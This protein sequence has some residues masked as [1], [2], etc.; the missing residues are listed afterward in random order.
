[1]EEKK[2]KQRAQQSSSNT[3]PRFSGPQNFHNRPTQNP[4]QQQPQFQRYSNN[5]NYQYQRPNCQPQQNNAQMQRSNNQ[6]PR[7]PTPTNTPVKTGTP[8]PP[9]SANCFKCGGTGHWS[10]QC[11]HRGTPQQTPQQN[12]K[13]S[14]PN[15]ASNHAKINHITAEAAQEGPNAVVG[16]FLV[17]SH[18]ALVPFDTGATHSFAT[19]QHVEKYNLPVIKMVC[20]LNVT[21]DIEFSIELVPGTAPI[22]KKAYRIAGVELLEVKKQIDEL[23]EKGFIRKS[24]SPWA[25]LVLLTEKKDGTLRMCV[26]YRGL[27]A[28]TVKN[29]YPLPQIEDLFDQLKS[30]CVFFK[31][32]LRMYDFWIAEVKFQGH[33]I[34][35]GGIA[36]AQSKEGNVIA[37]AFK[38]PRDHEKNYPTHDL[39][40]AA[41]V[42]A[43]KTELN[44]RQRRW[45]ELIKDYDLEIHYHPGKANVVADALSRKSTVSMEF[46]P[47]LEQEIRKGQLNDE[48]IKEIRE[49]IKLDKAPGFRVDAD[50][51]KF[52]WYGMKREVAEYVALCDVCQRVKAKHQKP[53]GLLQPLK[54][55]EWK[56]EEIGMNFIVG[57][58]RTQ[59]GFDSIWVVVD[60][61]TKVA[62]FI[63]V[64][65]IYSGAKLAE[66]Y[67]SRIVCLHG[68][69]KKIVSDRETQFT[70]HFWKRLHESMDTRL[71]F[72]SAYHPQTDGQTKRTNQILEDMLRACAIQYGTSWDKSLPYAEFSYNN[73]Y[74]A[75]IKMSPFQALYGRRCRTPLH[76]DQP[77][78]KQLF[79]PE[80][81]EDAE[82]QV[83]MIRENLRIAQT[84]QKSY[85][86]YR[87]RD[88]EFVVG[89]FLYLKVSPIRGLHRFKVKGKLV[90]RYIGP[91]K[92]ID[93]KGEVAY[94]LELPDR[95]LG[96]HGM[97]HVSQ[98]KKCLRV[99]E[100]QLQEYDLN[101]QDDLT[102]TEHPVQILEMAQMTT[103]NRV[104]NM[105][106]VKWSHH[107]AEETTW[108][109]EDDLGA[110]YPEL[111]A[112]QS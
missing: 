45:L 2:R 72:S 25:S 109:R 56:W 103:R 73:S 47:T 54:I 71:N 86:D 36:V 70:S 80:I 12:S 104:I 49:L 52:W 98:L 35:N 39:E 110:D 99:P 84:R 5:G 63:P 61:L 13:M 111:F 66:L 105:C 60:R 83:R 87:R 32:D 27:N 33:V 59:S 67:M 21:F 108:E 58:P 42:H 97:F 101:V 102:Y 81:I 20:R 38:Q 65:T 94:Q 9:G 40:L 82:R 92:I 57:I 76:W 93:R 95:L 88:L 75:S 7:Q 22:Y 78:E 4:G 44:M 68:V 37:Y 16:T 62:H 46:E 51:T 48:K 17:N 19:A 18:P 50:G 1:M 6:A 29:K 74:Q 8:V 11:P 23:L 31:I 90:P 100:E 15:Q 112:S 77:R 43:L 85:A 24:T 28:V 106:K 91:F 64:K 26:D 79:G 3:R 30:A 53:A 10:K 55:P 89:D 107:T 69:P 41:V 14:N 34:S 96:V